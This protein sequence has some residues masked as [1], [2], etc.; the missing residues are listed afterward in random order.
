M[1]YAGAVVV[2]V[3]LIIGIMYLIYRR[4]MAI[5][6]TLL[7]LGILLPPAMVS[8]YLGKEGITLASVTVALIFLLPIIIGLFAIMIKRIVNPLRYLTEIANRLAE[9]DLAL[10]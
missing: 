7:V 9:G 3:S 10:R 8:F 4:G 1:I 5:N 6:L 2:G